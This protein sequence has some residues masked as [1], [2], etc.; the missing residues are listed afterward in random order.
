MTSK[1]PYGREFEHNPNKQL[2]RV[3]IL[4]QIMK[5]VAKSKMRLLHTFSLPGE[6]CLFEQMLAERCREEHVRLSMICAEKKKSIFNKARINLPGEGRVENKDMHGKKD[7]HGVVREPI[8]DGV[9]RKFNVIWAD[10]CQALNA[11]ELEEFTDD[12]KYVLSSPGIYYFTSWIH[13]R[14]RGKS[15]CVNLIHGKRSKRSAAVEPGVTNQTVRSEIE[16]AF[17]SKLREK[18]VRV[19]KIYDVVYPGGG[20]EH[21]PMVTMGFMKGVRKGDP[22]TP[23][24]I[25]EDRMAEI[26]KIRAVSKRLNKSEGASNRDIVLAMLRKGAATTTITRSTGLGQHSVAAIKAWWTKCEVKGQQW[27]DGTGVVFSNVRGQFPRV[28][29]DA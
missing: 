19:R 20:T 13:G 23:R 10:F 4:S 12:M 18:G 21:T 9:N 17:V 28:R 8:F 16:K 22:R 29:S 3:D 24:P 5:F 11:E 7:T 27:N 25:V 14:G 2:V 1:V 15:G 6:M 26:S